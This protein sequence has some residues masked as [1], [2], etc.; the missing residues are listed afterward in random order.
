MPP[1]ISVVML[2]HNTEK[3]VKEAIQ[4]VLDQTFPDFELLVLDDCSTDHTCDAVAGIK[5]NR[6]RLVR[7][8]AKSS[9]PVLRNEGMDM[10]RGKYL[11]VMDSDDTAPPYRLRDQYDFLQSHPGV[12]VV[13]GDF[14]HLGAD[15]QMKCTDFPADNDSICYDFFFRC[16]VSNSAATIRLNTIRA[17]GVRYR[18]E[19]YVCSDYG[20]WIDMIPRA[21]FRNLKGKPYQFYRTGHEESITTESEATAEKLTVRD[22]FV[23]EM[24]RNL[25]VN[26][27]LPISDAEY[28]LFCRFFAY[29][30]FVNTPEDY[31]KL[32]ALFSRLKDRA[33][34]AGLN[35][36]VFGPLLDEWLV[37]GR[38]SVMVNG[39]L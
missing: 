27:G 23:N 2:T 8:P 34:T 11:A 32:G 31:R 38:K 12:D 13:A 16:H 20:F 29:R 28:A 30:N 36:A 33:Q 21:Q 15:G 1:A 5:D 17:L 25:F 19:Y 9:I 6:I 10:A 26:L 24:R 35:M 39:G 22:T 3:Y 18:T 4:S 14:Q 7:H 37:R